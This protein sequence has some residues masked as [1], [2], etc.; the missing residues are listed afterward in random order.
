MILEYHNPVMGK[1]TWQ[2]L[3]R[4]II[5]DE[6]GISLSA[7]QIDAL[8]RIYVSAIGKVSDLATYLMIYSRIKGFTYEAAQSFVD[9]I[10]KAK[11]DAP[12]KDSPFDKLL[13][14]GGGLL[15]VAGILGVAYIMVSV[16]KLIPDKR[17]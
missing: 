2:N 1:E 12:N 4:G 7:H 17:G 5:K 9:N 6:S 14:A 13:K 11:K 15:V 16:N 3:L 10:K 8:N